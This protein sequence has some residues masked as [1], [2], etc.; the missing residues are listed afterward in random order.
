[1]MDTGRYTLL[2]SRVMRR[3]Y[4]RGLVDSKGGNASLRVRLGGLDV[5]LITPSGVWKA[6]IDPDDVAALTLDGVVL[7]GRPSVEYPMHLEIYRRLGASAVV[8]AHN[9]LATA[10]GESTLLEAM[11][12]ETIDT[13]IASVPH[14]PSGSRELAEAVASRMAESGCRLVVIEG[15]GVVAAAHGEPEKALL[16]ALDLVESVE[17]A[18]QRLLA[19]LALGAARLGEALRWPW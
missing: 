1:L 11:L 16:K 13:C 7:Y 9:P 2:L 3:L 17:L 6:E 4:E 12:P 14:Y 10:L 15:H 18:A 5:V 8:H 19:R